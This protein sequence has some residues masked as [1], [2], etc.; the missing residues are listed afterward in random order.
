MIIDSAVV[1][2]LAEWGNSPLGILTA[3]ILGLLRSIPKLMGGLVRG[4]RNAPER[5]LM[6]VLDAM[7]RRASSKSG[8]LF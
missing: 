5:I 2:F 8:G 3:L 4:I 7:D 1:G 6:R